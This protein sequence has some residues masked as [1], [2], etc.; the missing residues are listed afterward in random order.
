MATS[1]NGLQYPIKITQGDDWVY[2]EKISTRVNGVKTPLDL[3]GATVSGVVRPAYA[4]GTVVPMTV[5]INNAAQGLVTFQLSD[6]QT[7][8]LPSGSLVYQMTYTI[9]GVTTTIGSGNFIVRP[10]V[11]TA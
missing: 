11:Q 4:T 8:S 2:P 9:A 6:T 10:K 7:S 3:T 1:Y 5:I